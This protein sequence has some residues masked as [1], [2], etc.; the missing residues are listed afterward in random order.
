MKNWET[1]EADVNVLMN[2]HY[3]AGRNSPIRHIVRHHNAG[4]NLTTRDCWNLWQDR[5]ASAHYQVEVDGT[6][7]QL[8][9]DWD[10]AWHAADATENAQSIGI[11]HANTGGAAQD[12]P[13]SAETIDNGAHLAA[14]LCKLYGLGRPE[15][16]KNIFDHRDFYG[17]SCPYT[18]APG[19]EGHALWMDAAQRWYDAMT[20]AG[21]TPTP[22][23][24]GTDMDARQ[25]HQLDD[26]HGQ[27]TGSTEPGQFP[28]WDQLGGRTL[29]DALAAV[30]EA[31]KVPGFRDPRGK[32]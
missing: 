7:G 28:G 27:L 20:G 29:V 5:E 14:A 26:N 1:V 4:V 11:E 10:T 32:P 24:R 9:N 30:G 17:T 23:P 22:T 19:G 18:L 31:L 8:V 3:T 15:Y 12:W 13:I 2:V 21:P 16:H 25:A 6:I